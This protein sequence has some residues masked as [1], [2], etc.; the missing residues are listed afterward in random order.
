[1]MK[2]IGLYSLLLILIIVQSCTTAYQPMETSAEAGKKKATTPLMSCEHIRI[3]AEWEPHEATWILWPGRYEAMYRDEFA[4]IIKVIQA[5]EP[6]VIGY[7]NSKLRQNALEVLEDHEVPL[8]NIR[9]EQI[10][11]DNAWLRDNGPVY[12][13]GCDTQ[14]AQDW[15]FD[16]WGKAEWNNE[17]LPYKTDNRIPRRIGSVLDM[18][19]DIVDDYILERGNLESNGAG[20]VLLNWDCQNKRQPGWTKD[21]TEELFREKFGV[22][23][24]V[25]IPSSDPDEFTGGHIDGMARFINRDTVVIPKAVDPHLPGASVFEEAAAAVEAAGLKVLRMDMP[26]TFSFDPGQPGDSAAEMEAIYINWLVGNG[27]VLATGFGLPEWDEPARKAIQSYFPDHDVHMIPTPTIWY[28]GGGV[29]C[30]TNDQP[31]AHIRH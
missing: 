16:A 18:P 11:N 21:E 27:F 22:E 28:Y 1:M 24:I 6:V 8:E 10:A 20:I 13:V 26:G 15:V 9:F 29:H 30:V 25:W 31:A 19:V 7:H 4:E 2:G 12:A 17:P 5:Y 14:W 3:P 23:Q